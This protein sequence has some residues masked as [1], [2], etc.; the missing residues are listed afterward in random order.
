M[1]DI[2]NKFLQKCLSDLKKVGI[3][4][5]FDQDETDIYAFYGE[6]LGKRKLDNVVFRRGEHELKICNWI[7]FRK[8]GISCILESKKSNKKKEENYVKL[9]PIIDEEFYEIQKQM[10]EYAIDRKEKPVKNENN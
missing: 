4:F 2:Q 7:F 9:H 1:I 10:I 3:S 6:Y 5:E 8:G